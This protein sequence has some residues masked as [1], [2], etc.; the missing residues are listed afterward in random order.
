MEVVG[1]RHYK[2]GR[3]Q[4]IARKLNGFRCCPLIRG[5]Y[6]VNALYTASLSAQ[7]RGFNAVGLDRLSCAICLLVFGFTTWLGG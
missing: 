6:A 7:S 3:K 1:C 4:S 2:F 5:T